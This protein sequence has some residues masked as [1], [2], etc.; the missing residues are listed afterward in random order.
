MGGGT[1]TDLS[2]GEL[3]A[4]LQDIESLDALPST[5]VEVSE[6]GL[7]IEHGERR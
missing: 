2:D 7:P 4:L 3:S 1:I 5:E 6:P